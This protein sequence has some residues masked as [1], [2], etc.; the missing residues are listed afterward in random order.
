MANGF[1]WNELV[2]ESNIMVS[3]NKKNRRP[4]SLVPTHIVIHITGS[5]DLA[6]VRQLFLKPGS[7][8]AHYLITPAGEIFQFVRDGERAFHAGI[9]SST[10]ALYRKGLPVW[11][12][13]LRYFDWY[14]A[15]P[16]DAVFVDGDIKPVW[17]KTEALFVAR[18]DGTPWAQFDYFTSRW[19]GQDQPVNFTVDADP[20]NYSIGI[21][22]HGYGSTEK[23]ETVY[24][25]RMYSALDVLTRNLS[26]KYAIPRQKG[27]I[28]GHEDV[29]PITRFG[30]DP[31]SGFD[32][33]LLHS[34]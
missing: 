16:E 2:A 21:E 19:P 32:W 18:R 10:R 30:W 22:C 14:K 3:P 20:N 29:N 7:V 1:E 25:E 28:V 31:N 34:S 27:R 26:D 33:S 24:T 17:D 11:T 12:R 5:D 6:S 8:S 4:A 23:D 9:N 13:Y 15:Y